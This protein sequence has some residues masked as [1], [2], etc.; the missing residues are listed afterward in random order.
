MKVLVLPEQLIK[1]KKVDIIV[2][3]Q[4]ICEKQIL[5]SGLV[6]TYDLLVIRCRSKIFNTYL[7]RCVYF[8]LFMTS[9]TETMNIKCRK[10]SFKAFKMKR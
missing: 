10:T 4:N 1:A 5:D 7:F 2:Y 3:F 6:K 8:N 9:K